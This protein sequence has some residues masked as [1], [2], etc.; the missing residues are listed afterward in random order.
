MWARI[1]CRSTKG[2]AIRQT[3]TQSAIKM[4]F[5]VS[6]NVCQNQHEPLTGLICWNNAPS[7]S[8]LNV[9]QEQ[10][11]NFSNKKKIS[12]W[13]KN[14]T[15]QELRGQKGQLF[16][17]SCYRTHALHRSVERRSTLSAW[18]TENESDEKNKTKI[19]WNPLR[20]FV[21][22]NFF[23]SVAA[24]FWFERCVSCTTTREI[25]R[26]CV[27]LHGLWPFTRTHKNINRNETLLMQKFLFQLIVYT[28]TSSS[29]SID[30][31]SVTDQKVIQFFKLT[32]KAERMT[33][34][35]NM[36]TLPMNSCTHLLHFSPVNGIFFFAYANG[37]HPHALAC[38]K[39]NK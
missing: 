9:P 25:C 15:K 2:I 29:H 28:F 16:L 33:K 36:W 21:S 37:T 26:V 17:R 8:A 32:H 18:M 14:D 5:I 3:I 23:S 39:S 30:A 19:R 12:R 35:R 11:N 31:V 27:G 13:N 38:T 22:V 34:I 10:F 20:C 24:L 4:L 7:S 1:P 6:A